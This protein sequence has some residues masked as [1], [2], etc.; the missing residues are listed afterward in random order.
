MGNCNEKCCGK[1][2]TWDRKTKRCVAPDPLDPGSFCGP[3]THLVNGQCVAPDPLD[4]GSF[5]GPNTNLVNGICIAPFPRSF[6][7]TNTELNGSRCTA[8]VPDSF[9]G[10]NTELKDGQCRP[11]D[12]WVATP[13]CAMKHDGCELTNKWGDGNCE[14][15]VNHNPNLC[16]YSNYI[17]NC[18][19]RCTEQ[20]C[21]TTT[22]R[23]DC[24]YKH[25]NCNWY[26][27]AS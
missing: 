2:M 24:L 7:G 12:L 6:C 20:K 25:S 13:R 3:N 1:D 8:P 27:Y 26:S 16:R 10:P 11:K 18:A 23:K 5:C 17:E 4:P 9:C 22:S 14:I 15:W 21:R 19:K